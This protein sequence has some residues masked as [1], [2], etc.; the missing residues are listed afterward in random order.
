VR[1]S[2]N[3]AFDKSWG[4]INGSL[5]LAWD[6]VEELNVKANVSS[7]YRSGNLAELGSSGLHEGTRRWEIGDPE[8]KVESNVSAEIGFTYEWE[9]QVELSASVYRNTFTNYI[10]LSPTD[11]D[12]LGLH[13]YRFLQTNATLQGG[14]ASLDVHPKALAWLDVNISY[15]HVQAHKG[16]GTPL[17]FIPA[18]RIMSSVRLLK[19]A[20]G[21]LKLGLSHITAQNTPAQFETRTLAYTLY[22][23]SAGT[24]LRWNAHPLE[25]DLTCNNLTDEQY[26]DHLSRFKNFGLRDMGRNIVL[27]LHLD[28]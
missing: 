15:S 3:A 26:V 11:E 20:R 19:K 27:T 10:Y 1:A 8:L 4:A 25:I 16:D 22:M 23:I 17:P 24:T 12:T 13:I 6:P 28:F 18:D 9:E 7:G 14:E 5:G 21:W 2:I